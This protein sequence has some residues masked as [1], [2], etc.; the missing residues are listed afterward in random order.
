MHIAP[1][2]L[3]DRK[4]TYKELQDLVIKN[5]FGVLPFEYKG[6]ACG[7]SHGIDYALVS[8]SIKV[9]QVTDALDRFLAGDWGTFYD[10]PGDIVFPGR[11]YGE[12]PSS[13]GSK[14]TNGAIMVHR[15]PHPLAPWAVV[16]YFQFER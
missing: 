1:D 12:Y 4:L 16:V 3:K 9:E 6:V 8:K 10:I 7:V 11:E 13:Y 5:G 2:E 14:T 15:E